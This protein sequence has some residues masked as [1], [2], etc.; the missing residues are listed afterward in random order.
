MLFRSHFVYDG[1]LIE[2]V[3]LNPVLINEDSVV[4]PETLVYS[5]LISALLVT[6]NLHWM[7]KH[8]NPVSDEQIDD[9]D[10]ETE[11]DTLH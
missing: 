4:P 8:G 2:L 1:I 3:Y 5:G 10:S 6:M 11:S 9:Q 7:I